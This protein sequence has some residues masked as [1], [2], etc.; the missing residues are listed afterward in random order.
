MTTN[1]HHSRK[2]RKPKVH[3]C[4]CP[5]ILP[6]VEPVPVDPTPPEPP[7]VDPP[8]VTVPPEPPPVV[9]L[10]PEPVPLPP[11]PPV[12]PANCVDAEAAE[13]IRLINVQR[14][15]AG[16]VLLLP[17]RILIETAQSWSEALSLLGIVS[18][19]IGDVL[20][21]ASIRASTYPD[22]YRGQVA[23]GGMTSPEQLVKAWM[24]SPTHR[25]VIMGEVFREI[26]VGHAEAAD[27]RYVHYHVANLGSGGNPPGS[28]PSELAALCG[29]VT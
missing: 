2:R 9:V 29:G 10:P 1:P 23:S 21:S 16:L 6:P 19:T 22:S 5:P 15:M 26:G 24:D 20:W 12:P 13:I 18:H 14:D 25:S 3:I 8:I 7:P 17:S 28:S 4:P 27:T 11:A